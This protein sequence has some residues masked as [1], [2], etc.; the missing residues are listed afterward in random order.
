MASRAELFAKLGYTKPIVTPILDAAFKNEEEQ[1]WKQDLQSSPH[2]QHWHLSFHASSFPG[3][4]PKACG[5]QALYSLMNIPA[6]NPIDRAGRSVMEAG[7][8]IEEIIVWRLYRT[9]LL[10]TDPPDS[11]HQMGF[12]DEEHWLTGSPDAIIKN[13]TDNT[14]FPIEIKSKDGEVVEQMQQGRRS[15][16]PAHRSQVLTYIG[17]TYERQSILWPDL[18]PLKAGAILYAS[19]NRPSEDHEFKFQ[20]NKDFMDKGYEK[21]SE[22][23]ESYL[24]EEL[25]QTQEKKHPFGWKW[26]EPPCK[27]CPIKKVCKADFQAGITSLSE[28]HGIKHAEEVRGNYDYDETRNAVLERWDAN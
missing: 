21:L 25:P 15:F 2:G 22:W 14:P 23:K 28:S 5:R 3:D 4:N 19:R 26:T 16:D 9:G 17:L 6:F 8:A 10:L 20:Y 1:I 24:N 11:E 13:P 18:E 27:W 7:K 12:E